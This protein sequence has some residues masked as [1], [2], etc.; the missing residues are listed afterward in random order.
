MNDIYRELRHTIANSKTVSY[1]KKAKSE[2]EPL[3][4]TCVNLMVNKVCT[5]QIGLSKPLAEGET[6]R[7]NCFRVSRCRKI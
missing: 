2:V 7:R 6:N 4:E 1:P 5:Q 3:S